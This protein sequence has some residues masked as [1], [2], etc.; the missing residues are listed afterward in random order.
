MEFQSSNFLPSGSLMSF[1]LSNSLINLKEMKT[2]SSLMGQKKILEAA[3]LC[4]LPP[5]QH[6]DKWTQ[7]TIPLL[8]RPLLWSPGSRDCCGVGGLMRKGGST[9]RPP[10]AL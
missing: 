3:L 10:S 4:S 9:S 2:H 6:S 5:H 7:Q 1:K 8:D